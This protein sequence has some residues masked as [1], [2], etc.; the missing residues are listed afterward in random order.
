MG[1]RQPT[2]VTAAGG[3]RRSRISCY[4]AVV[5]TATRTA[6]CRAGSCT[7]FSRTRTGTSGLRFLTNA[8]HKSGGR[9]G[10]T[11]RK[12]KT[13]N[14]EGLVGALRPASCYAAVIATT[15]RTAVCRTGT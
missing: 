10:A 4:A 13:I 11:P 6:V 9:G 8:L 3:I 7:V 12:S 1:A 14:N 2:S 15:T 5:A